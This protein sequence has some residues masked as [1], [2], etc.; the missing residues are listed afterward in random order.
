MQARP[1]KSRAQMEALQQP[2]GETV[3]WL[4]RFETKWHIKRF[5]NCQNSAPK[6]YPLF[7]HSGYLGQ[8]HFIY[9]ALCK[10]QMNYN[11]F[12]FPAKFS[13]KCYRHTLAGAAALRSLCTTRHETAINGRWHEDKFSLINKRPKLLGKKLSHLCNF[14]RGKLHKSSGNWRM[15]CSWGW[16]LLYNLRLRS[17]P[18]N[19]LHDTNWPKVAFTW[20]VSRAGVWDNAI[21]STPHQHWIDRYTPYTIVGT[22]D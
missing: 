21:S 9:W 6:T 12:P 20:E 5:K 18:S 22:S 4:K 3:K 11:I 1:E 19:S 8:I 13:A 15:H 2:F 16:H 17:Y 7:S 14:R 10:I